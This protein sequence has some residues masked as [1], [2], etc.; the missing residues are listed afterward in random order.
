MFSRLL[1]ILSLVCILGSTASAELRLMPGTDAKINLPQGYI[2]VE[3][4][5]ATSQELDALKEFQKNLP[6]FVKVPDP[7]LD[8]YNPKTG[9]ELKIYTAV[10][11]YSLKMWDLRLHQDLLTNT[12]YI[13]NYRKLLKDRFNIN[14][15][16]EVNYYKTQPAIY[17]TAEGSYKP[18]AG[19]TTDNQK[20]QVD[21]NGTYQG[22]YYI[23]LYGTLRDQTTILICG[24]G[25]PDK[26]DILQADVKKSVDTIVYLLPEPE[27]QMA[28]E[29]AAEKKMSPA[30]EKFAIGFGIFVVLAF[31]AYLYQE[32]RSKKE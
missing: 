28:Q 17:V 5:K 27:V 29:K 3:P 1:L 30:A 23:C 32:H 9:T 6:P 20:V 8:A 31:L 21:A 16:K 26:K 22:D 4:E 24:S 14:M 7:D 15:D 25:T 12:S 18:V 11:S 2:V 10:N 19:N 13:E